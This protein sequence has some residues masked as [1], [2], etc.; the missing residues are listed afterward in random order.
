MA[1]LLEKRYEPVLFAARKESAPCC[2]RRTLDK[3]EENRVRKAGSEV[4]RVH[5]D[6]GGGRRKDV[7]RMSPS[8]I[9]KRSAFAV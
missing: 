4:S 7:I 6:D 8:V 3:K 1:W 2:C 5:C 9:N